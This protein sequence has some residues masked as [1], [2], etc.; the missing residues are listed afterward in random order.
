MLN[1]VDDSGASIS[2]VITAPNQ[3]AYSRNAPTKCGGEDYT[4]LVRDVLSRWSQEKD[5]LTD[6]GRV[7]PREYMWFYGS[8]GRNW[9]RDSVKGGQRWDWSLGDPY[10]IDSEHPG[11]LHDPES[12][13]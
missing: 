13:S 7:L 6:V 5:G 9:F 8:G 11:V 10:V 3:F 12:R 1:R 4:L 2:K